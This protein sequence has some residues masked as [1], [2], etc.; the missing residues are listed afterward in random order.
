MSTIFSQLNYLTALLKA[1]PDTL[2]YKSQAESAYSFHD[3]WLPDEDVDDLGL[4]G[5]IN[6]QLEV[7]LGTR[8]TGRR[9][10]FVLQERGPGTV[11]LVDVLR[12]Y[13]TQFPE[14][15]LLQKWV[16][17]AC[18][19]AENAYDDAG[20]KIPD[21]S[22]VSASYF[23]DSGSDFIAAESAS[24]SE[25]NQAILGKVSQQPSKKLPDTYVEQCLGIRHDSKAKGKQKAKLRDREAS[26]AKPGERP[27]TKVLET[28]EDDRYEDLGEE[29][30]L[31]A[32]G[33]PIEPL[34]LKVSLRC[35]SR[36]DST[37][38]VL[39]RC[40]A[41]RGC[42]TTWVAPRSKARV[43]KH[44]AS[45]TWLPV[46]LRSAADELIAAKA[47]N[48]DALRLSLKRPHD[49]DADND[50]GPPT[51]RSASPT[52]KCARRSL[53][54]DISTSTTSA[55]SSKPGTLDGV[56]SNQG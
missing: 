46:H 25:A 35:R 21:I 17:D 56:F 51:D 53:S 32:G 8:T 34:L 41:S 7:R 22:Q 3:F 12:K 13:T 45:C 1:L 43:L 38:K 23:N 2:P 36:S 54:S 27:S 24:E 33:R 50:A 30:D 44:V 52:A 42:G 19:A 18:R 39:V 16:D 55:V 10:T 37:E 47:I 6:R 29:P 15:V 48:S 28:F 14:D 9:N 26:H 31:R 11:A 4:S 20:V 49:S 40:L 5:A